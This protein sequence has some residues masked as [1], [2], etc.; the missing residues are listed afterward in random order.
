MA[1]TPPVVWKFGTCK[2]DEVQD[3]GRATAGRL[4]PDRQHAVAAAAVRVHGR[5][6]CRPVAPSLLQ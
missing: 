2:V 5:R 1:N 4:Q 6:G 3:A